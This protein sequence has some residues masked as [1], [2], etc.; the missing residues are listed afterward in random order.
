[1]RLVLLGP[2]GAGKGT[3]AVQI[4][5]AYGV[6]QIATGDIFRENVAAGTELGR[7]AKG[8]MDAGDLVPDAVVI[9]MVSAR[10]TQDDVLAGFVLDGF[11]RTVAQAQALEEVLANHGTPLDVVLRFD[12]P[13]PEL[14]RRIVHRRSCPNDGS[15]Y[16][17]EFAPP[18]R[19]LR[20][21]LCGAKLVQRP[22]DTEDVVRRRLEEYR[23]K[24]QQL[25]HFYA[26]RGLLRD[27]EAQG[28]VDDVTRRTLEV[29]ETVA[30]AGS[31]TG[32]ASGNHDA[33]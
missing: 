7:E 20:C 4:A 1:M 12:V 14:V 16:H 6:P 8:Y 29:L 24:T 9:G 3:Q 19:D 32:R 18:K 27:V 28:D 31:A 17:L 26:E 15:V 13:E 21:D 30:P 2:P 23:T 5:R 33:A 25:E 10:L 11:P 22:D